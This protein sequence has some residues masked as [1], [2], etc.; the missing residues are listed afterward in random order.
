MKEKKDQ[1]EEI[2]KSEYDR[3]AREE[4]VEIQNDGDICVPEGMQDAIRE[5]IENRIGEI[6]REK[7]YSGLSEEDRRALE[8]GRKML[9][10]EEKGENTVKVVRKRK[11]LKI[12]I[13]LVAVLVIVL[14]MGIT[15]VGGPEKIVKM[16]KQAVG[17]REVE[18][19]N[20]SEDNLIVVEENEEEA[21]QTISDEF[22]IEPVRIM[23]RPAGMKFQS[24]DLDKELQTAEMIYILEGENIVY[25]IN[26]AYS[27]ASLGIDVEDKKVN[28]FEIENAQCRITVKEYRIDDSS[29]ARYSAS[30]GYHELEYFLV[31]TMGEGDFYKIINNLHFFG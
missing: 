12:Y 21:Y 25:L 29:M 3:M 11:P 17:N 22:G 10:E 14:G 27:D 7:S 18:K 19:I 31:G 6:K 8:L 20:A 23:N 1:L 9:A 2:V 4:E 15:S 30:F 16:V 26:A 5:R 24:L 28:Q 13:G